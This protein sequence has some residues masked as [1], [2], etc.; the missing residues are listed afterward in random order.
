MDVE[1][2]DDRPSGVLVWVAVVFLIMIV[3]V[4]WHVAMILIG[5]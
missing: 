3:W 1:D 2:N 4:G 5:P